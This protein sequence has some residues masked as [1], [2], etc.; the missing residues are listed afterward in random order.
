MIRTTHNGKDYL[1]T[2]DAWTGDWICA[3][4]GALRTSDACCPVSK[5]ISY[6]DFK[7]QYFEKE[8]VLDAV[9]KEFYEDYLLGD[10]QSLDDYI[11]DT[12]GE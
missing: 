4:C 9:A 1:W 5:Y 2:A 12:K 3:V 6:N 11:K 10:Y 8:D 7:E